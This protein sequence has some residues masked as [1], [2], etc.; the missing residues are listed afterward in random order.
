M[1]EA[2]LTGSLRTQIP[3]QVLDLSLGGALVAS[4]AALAIGA[5]HEFVLNLEG[6]AIRVKAEVRHCRAVGPEY[7]VGVRFLGLDADQS[8]R[9]SDFIQ[10][11]KL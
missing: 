3:A 11:H 4:Q 7:H 2:P 5:V 1:N 8:Q 10:R 6:E 9:L